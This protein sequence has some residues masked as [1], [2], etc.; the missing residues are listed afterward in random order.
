M[1]LYV[2]LIALHHHRHR[3][4]AAAA[5]DPAADVENGCAPR[6]TLSSLIGR[7]TSAQ[8]FV[9]LDGRVVLPLDA[10]AL[11]W[12]RIAARQVTAKWAQCVILLKNGRI[13]HK[14]FCVNVIFCCT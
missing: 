11:S 6:L 13:R 2:V 7:L 8:R 14:F 9:L 1:C 12:A 3:R 4:H 5:A 10:G